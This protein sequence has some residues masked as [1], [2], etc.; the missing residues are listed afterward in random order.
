MHVNDP[1]TPEPLEVLF[2]TPDLIVRR[3]PA[4]GGAIGFV[5]FSAYSHERT[6]DRA[7]FGEAFLA[8]R[9]IDAIHVISRANTWFDDP[10]MAEALSIVAGAIAVAGHDRVLTYGSS[11]GGY[12]A[13]RFAEAVGATTAIAL[14]PQ[15]GLGGRDTAFEDRFRSERA[16]RP[17]LAPGHGSNAVRPYVFF[18]PHDLDARHMR[19]IAAA[20]PRAVAIPLPHAGHPVGPYL[21]E[22][23]LLTAAILDIAHGRFQAAPFV[24]K[25]RRARST[26]SQYLFTLA[27]RLGP[28][29]R[30]AKIA[31]IRKAIAM[32]DDATYRLYLGTLLEMGGD[33]EAAEAEGLRALALLPDHAV[34]LYARATFLMRRGRLAEAGP[35]AATLVERWPENH[36]FTQIATVIAARTGGSAPLPPQLA[37]NASRRLAWT[38]WLGLVGRLARLHAGRRLP[39]PRW[40]E[41]YYSLRRELELI[42]EWRRR[43]RARRA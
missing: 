18:D 39:L 28:A 1:T 32:R 14:S 23:G 4:R 35:I 29:H 2:R 38:A 34:S 3:G 19:L 25:A 16:G 17:V 6:L 11:M 36:R 24:A 8:S 26:S 15:Y 22:T 43:R 31:L 37:G 30:A 9:G 5:T 12:A 13:I 42:D 27:R 33:I 7:G 41:R 10:R 21:D 20:Y 40:H